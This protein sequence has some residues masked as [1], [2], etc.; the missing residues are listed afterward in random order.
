MKPLIGITTVWS[1]ELDLC[2][3]FD[4]FYY[5]N[6]AYIKAIFAAGGIPVLMPPPKAEEVD[7][8]AHA[9]EL[10]ASLDA[11]Y[12]AGGGTVGKRKNPVDPKPR[13]LYEQQPVRSKWEDILLKK[14][15]ALDMPITGACRGHQMIAEA[16]GGALDADYY[17]PHKQQMPYYEGHHTVKLAQNS[18]LSSLVGP[19]DWF[20]NSVHTQA[21]EKLPEGFIV[22]AWTED[23]SVE[24][25]E[26]TE[27]TFVL[28]TQ[29]HPEM[30][31][32]DARA[33]KVLQA[34]V[35]AA[36]AYSQRK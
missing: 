18:L 20:V 13:P 2:E 21:V 11:V 6:C 30:M 14:A 10:L 32:Y 1:P 29:F 35:A 28:G 15:Y 25:I 27:K 3:V 9:D 16:L 22:S 23:G 34:F 7:L 4:E 19:E 26:S 31:V 5:I 17:P 33:Q 36:K 8:E 12:F 24:A